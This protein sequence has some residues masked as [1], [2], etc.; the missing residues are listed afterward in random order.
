[1][2]LIFFDLDGTLVKGLSTEKR[3]FMFLLRGRTLGFPQLAA[4]IAFT[5]RR[6]KHSFEDVWKKNKAYLTGLTLNNI[7]R[8]A[9]QFVVQ[10]CLPNLRP[11]V[12]RRLD[13][14]LSQ[15]DIVVL[16]TGTPDFI[17][18]PIA[19]RL[20]IIHIA[21]T[22]CDTR[23]GRFTSAPPCVHPFGAAKLHIAD[24]MCRDFNTTLDQ[25]TAYADSA[26]DLALLASVFQP[27]AVY[28]DGKLRQIARRRGWEIIG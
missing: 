7:Q 14:H 8:L 23:N 19:R 21:A 27:V 11:V 2:A 25:C 10:A 24:R 5:L 26:S 20:N 28:P 12:K 18:R 13:N 1:M 15:G 16:L 4:F 17:A 6:Y 9:E 3:F 22:V